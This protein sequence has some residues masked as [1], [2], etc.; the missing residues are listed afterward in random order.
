MPLALVVNKSYGENKPVTRIALRKDNGDGT[1]TI[2][3]QSINSFSYSGIKGSLRLR[4]DEVS[5]ENWDDIAIMY[6]SE[7]RPNDAN[8]I[9]KIVVMKGEVTMTGL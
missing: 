9:Y 2:N 7:S 4:D 1:Y 3:K 6:E 5:L 8:V